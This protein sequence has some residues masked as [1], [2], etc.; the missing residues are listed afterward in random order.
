MS[1]FSV[2]KTDSRDDKELLLKL[3][4]KIGFKVLSLEEAE[5]ELFSKAIDAGLKSAKVD[6]KDIL[7]ALK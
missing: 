6:R 7:D 4:E 2:I 1:E 5:D 3:A